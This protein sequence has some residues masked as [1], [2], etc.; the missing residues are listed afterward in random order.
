MI[1]HSA[2]IQLANSSAGADFQPKVA[3]NAREMAF[4]V[5]L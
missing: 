5:L 3:A 1:R 2:P 4:D